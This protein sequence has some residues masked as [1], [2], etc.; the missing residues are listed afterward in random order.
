MNIFYSIPSM[1]YYK[2]MAMNKEQFRAITNKNQK[3]P[4]TYKYKYI[5][6]D[7]ISMTFKNRQN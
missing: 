5:S 6:C 2:A 7:S 4:D 1:E 3:K